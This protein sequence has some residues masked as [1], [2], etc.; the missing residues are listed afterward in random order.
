MLG[1][2]LQQRD[3]SQVGPCAWPF[4][5]GR[6]MRGAPYTLALAPLPPPLDMVVV[7]GGDLA[8]LMAMTHKPSAG[9]GRKVTPGR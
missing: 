8:R 1:G 5:V 2:G 9:A 7:Q 4:H 3:P 6:A